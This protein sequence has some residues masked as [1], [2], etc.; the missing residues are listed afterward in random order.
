MSVIKMKYIVFHPTRLSEDALANTADSEPLMVVFST[1]I[2][3]DK[4]AEAVRYLTKD[5]R[6]DGGWYS[7]GYRPISAGFTNG[8][9]CYGRSDTLNLGSNPNDKEYLP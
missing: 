4:M 1:H 2:D 8:K 7:P 5:S 9:D 6:A 3:H